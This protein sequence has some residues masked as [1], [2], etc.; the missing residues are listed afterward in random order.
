MKPLYSVKSLLDKQPL[1]LAAGAKII[2]NFLVVWGIVN[3]S[4]PKTAA[5]LLLVEGVATL[6]LKVK[7]TSN[8]KL[9]ELQGSTEQLVSDTA[10]DAVATTQQ[11]KRPLRVER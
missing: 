9:D 4:G 3:V 11:R 1:E 8:A 6:L 2:V 5:L 10:V 7:M